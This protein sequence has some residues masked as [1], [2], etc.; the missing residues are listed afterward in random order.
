MHKDKE[1]I[2]NSTQPR[3]KELQDICKQVQASNYQH[4]RFGGFTHLYLNEKKQIEKKY[5]NLKIEIL[6]NAISNTVAAACV[7]YKKPQ[8]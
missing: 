5:P 4:F 8:K 6:G 1:D 7:I 3:R 2:F